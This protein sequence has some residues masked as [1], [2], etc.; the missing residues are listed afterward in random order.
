MIHFT[1]FQLYDG[2]TA[3]FYEMVVRTDTIVSLTE[4]NHNFGRMAYNRVTWE[5]ARL[6]LSTGAE[7]D[8]LV[9]DNLN[10]SS[11]E[12]VKF[13]LDEMGGEIKKQTK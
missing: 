5:V 11:S 1:I 10:F 6:T 7:H 8:V 12:I 2:A 9:Q 4:R 3:T 13:Y